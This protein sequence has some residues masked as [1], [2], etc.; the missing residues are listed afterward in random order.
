MGQKRRWRIDGRWQ[1]FLMHNGLPRRVSNG[2]VTRSLVQLAGAFGGVIVSL[3]NQIPSFA[4]GS[5]SLPFFVVQHSLRFDRKFPSLG[6]F[7][8]RV[9]GDQHISFDIQ[10]DAHSHQR[11]IDR[12]Q[13]G[14]F[15]CVGSCRSRLA[16][17]L[18]WIA[19]QWC[20]QDGLSGNTGSCWS[21]H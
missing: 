4:F 16:V 11:M 18:Q 12:Y 8:Q 14:C 2:L 3:G 20:C 15:P 1:T 21:E 19:Q 13:P 10:L 5:K 6:R 7:D 17:A 9:L